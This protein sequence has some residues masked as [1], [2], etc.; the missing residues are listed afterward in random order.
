MWTSASGGR[1]VCQLLQVSGARSVNLS[2]GEDVHGHK[3]LL[4]GYA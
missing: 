4:H 1:P 3:S 2:I